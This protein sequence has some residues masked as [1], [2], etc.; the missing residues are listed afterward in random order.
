MPCRETGPPRL[1]RAGGWRHVTAAG[2]DLA[3]MR[4]AAIA[5]ADLLEI[6]TER[7]QSVLP[8]EG[9]GGLQAWARTRLAGAGN[10]TDTP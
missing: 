1:T 6:A 4:R 8:F 3:D 9:P 2:L 10:P 5:L 7:A